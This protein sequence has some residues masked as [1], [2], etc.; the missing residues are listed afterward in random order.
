MIDG[1]LGF[2]DGKDPARAKDWN[3]LRS[4]LQFVSRIARDDFLSSL[5]RIMLDVIDRHHDLETIVRL[6][7]QKSL[8]DRWTRPAMA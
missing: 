4:G 2:L 6:L 3:A 7:V 1:N 8:H 5:V